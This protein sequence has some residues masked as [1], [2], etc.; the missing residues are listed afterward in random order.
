MCVCVEVRSK[1]RVTMATN[2]HGMVT[3]VDNVCV[4]VE[5]RSKYP[6]T[7]ATNNV[8]NDNVCV[9]VC[10]CVCGSYPVTMA[11]KTTRLMK[12]RILGNHVYTCMYM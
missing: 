11:T 10:V 12:Y 6:V 4:C 8:T 1:Y 9:C 3:N 2:N 7:M 5:V